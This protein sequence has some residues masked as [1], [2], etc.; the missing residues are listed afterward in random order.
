M[1]YRVRNASGTRKSFDVKFRDE[2]Q[3]SV[4]VKTLRQEERVKIMFPE[5]WDVSRR[6]MIR[7]KLKPAKVSFTKRKKK[8]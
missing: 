3:N 2:D 1:I 6:K 8:K 4:S 7:E 5:K